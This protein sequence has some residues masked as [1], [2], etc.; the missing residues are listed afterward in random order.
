MKTQTI[1]SDLDYEYFISRIGYIRMKKY[2]PSVD[3]VYSPYRKY[4][5]KIATIQKIASLD[6]TE[7][8]LFIRGACISGTCEEYMYDEGIAGSWF[9]N[10]QYIQVD[11]KCPICNRKIAYCISEYSDGEYIYFQCPHGHPLKYDL[12]KKSIS[13]REES[14]I[15]KVFD[16]IRKTGRLVSI[17]G[18]F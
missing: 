15:D 7:K 8:D 6:K 12:V 11:Q 17:W 16:Y 3:E 2:H 1:K 14:Q 13:L 9:L 18:E 10:H 4:K 5:E